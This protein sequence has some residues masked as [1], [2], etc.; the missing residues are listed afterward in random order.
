MEVVAAAWATLVVTLLLW[1]FCVFKYSSS[2]AR[3]TPTRTCALHCGMFLAAITAL[4]TTL[5]VKNSDE[6]TVVL[7]VGMLAAACM[8]CIQCFVCCSAQRDEASGRDEYLP[9]GATLDSAPN[10]NPIGRV[11]VEPLTF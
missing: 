1:F 4:I 11:R 2:F 8:V 5:I 6:T 3:C 9:P 10:T 7:V